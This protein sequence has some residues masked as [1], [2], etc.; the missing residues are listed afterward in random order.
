MDGVRA[1]QS[2]WA[3]LGHAEVSNFALVDEFLHLRERVFDWRVGIDAML[4]VEID[5]INA[6]PAQARLAG[7]ANVIGLSIHISRRQVV[8]VALVTEFRRQN[9]FVTASLNG[10]ADQFFVSKR[11]IHVGGVEEGDAEF[12]RPMNGRDGF[13]LIARAIKFGHSHA[14]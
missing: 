9:D 1:A 3:R 5:V 6:E 2:L 8:E 12:D 13:A 4:V 11:A 7:A 14:T 10:F